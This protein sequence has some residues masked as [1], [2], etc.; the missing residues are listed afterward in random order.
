MPNYKGACKNEKCPQTDQTVEVF[1]PRFVSVDAETE[2][3]IDL[4]CGS[5]RQKMLQRV[6]GMPQ[7]SKPILTR[8]LEEALIQH[9]IQRAKSDLGLPESVK[10]EARIVDAGMSK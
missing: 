10:V 3:Y 7:I 6:F 2:Q 9:S 1:S 8:G 5:C 4:E